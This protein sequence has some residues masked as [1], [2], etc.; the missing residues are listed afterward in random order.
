MGARPFTSESYA[1]CERPAL[2]RDVLASTGLSPNS[3]QA[4]CAGFATAVQRSSGPVMLTRLAADAQRLRP[5]G[6][7]AGAPP[8]AFLAGEDCLLALERGPEFA[9]PRGGLALLPLAHPWTIVAPRGVRAAVLAVS[10]DAA[11]ARFSA[12]PKLAE[13]RLAPPGGL[14]DV[15]AR[16]LEATAQGLET[17]E[18]AQWSAASA[19]L[20]DLFLTL[21][22]GL[23][24]AAGAPE[25][26]A[27]AALL[28]RIHQSLERRLDDPDLS[29]AEIAASVGVSERYLQ[30]LMESAGANFSHYVR[31]RRLRRAQ[32]DLMSPLEAQRSISE[33][34]YAYGFSDSA[35]FSRAFRQRFGQT[36]REFRREALGRGPAKAEPPGQRGW[37]SEALARRANA[38]SPPSAGP[39]LSGSPVRAAKARRHYLSV[40]A[41][42][43]HWGYFSR[44][45]SPVI[46]IASGDTITVETLTQHASDDPDLMIQGDAGAESVFGWTAA[47]KNV[48]R[49]GAGPLDASVFGRG[50]GEGFGVH[51]CTGPVAVKGAEPGDVLEVRVLDI[52]PRPSGNPAFAG[53]VFGS[54]VSAWWGYQYDDLLADAPLRETVTIFEIDTAAAVARAIYAYRWTPTVDPSGVLHAKYD[55]PGVPVRAPAARR[56]V[57]L[58]GV[59]IPLRPHFGVI[60]VAPRET[61]AIDSVPPAY[62]GGNLDNW[63]LGPGAA[64]YLPVSAPAALLSIGDPHATQGD[65]EVA[66]TAI[67]CSM[68]GTFEVVLHKQAHLKGRPFEDLTYPLIETPQEWILTGFSH[69]NY[70]AEFGAQAQSEVYAKSSLDLAMRDAFR[71]TRRFLMQVKGLSEDEAVALMSAAVDFGVTQV[72]DG[73]WGVHATIRKRLFAERKE[74]ESL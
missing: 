19:A 21:A 61:G 54:S 59:A 38:A 8:L 26:G 1:R 57:A 70:L 33:I 4:D 24:V 65:G 55:Y 66:G 23:A 52:S 12:A 35:H 41:S 58:D 49:R 53:R 46:E 16:A 6:A 17:L 30:K 40:D 7:P 18:E 69:P 71:K 73:N 62:F 72:V 44:A 14:T 29:P 63:R 45:L 36:P 34:A 67:E 43:V 27:Q 50:A 22:H 25:G 48:D 56:R 32:A 51:I 2:W 11:P 31:E 68:T 42:K 64:V 13:A 37:P 9:L 3:P 39:R 10:P 60:A 28:H 15:V 5:L 20:A 47:R 74:G